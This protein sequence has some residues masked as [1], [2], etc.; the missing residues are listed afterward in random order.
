MNDLFHEVVAGCLL[1]FT[2]A[3]GVIGT[4]LMCVQAEEA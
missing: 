3:V 1:G 2:A 4:I